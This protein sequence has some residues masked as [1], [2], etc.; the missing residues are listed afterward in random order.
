MQEEHSFKS[1]STSFIFEKAELLRDYA[2]AVE[3]REVSLLGRKDVFM[4]RA[5]FGIFGD[6]KELAQIALS[7]VFRKGD[8][9]SGYYRDQTLVAA[10]GGMTWEVFFA[11]L[12]AHPDV[13]FDKFSGGRSMNAHFGSPWLDEKGE[14]LDQ[15]SL[16]NHAMDVSSTAGQLP[17]A[18]GLAFA[19]KL[20]RQN[21]ELSYLDK[22]SKN[23]NEVCFATIGD[24]STS[25][26]M[27][28]ESINAA[29][30][31][32]IPVI[33]SV[34]DDGFGISVP[35]KYQTTKSS[36]STILEGFQTDENG[37][38]LEIIKVKGWDYPALIEAYQKAARYARDNH[39]PCLVHVYELT[40]PQG[41]SASG[42]HERY[43]SKERL[44]WEVD[45][46][47]NLRFRNWLLSEG[48]ASEKELLE[49]ETKASAR[50]KEA[51]Q[52]AWD[53][54]KS[55][56]ENSIGRATDLLEKAIRQ[57][58]S[59]KSAINTLKKSIQGKPHTLVK[60]AVVA[61]RRTQR[62]LAK[63][64]S[65]VKSEI[66][67]LIETLLKEAAQNYSSHLYSETAESPL[68]V[69]PEA[70][71]YDGEPKILSGHQ[72]IN[73]YF[74]GL[75]AREP[76]V[77]AI[78]EDIG[79][80]GDV[81]QGFAGLQSKYGDLR[82]DDTGIRE[83]TIIGQGIGAAMRGLRPIVEV[84]YFDYI[85]YC[86]SL[87]TDDLASLRYRTFG[88]Q[89]APLIVRTRGHRLE[90]IWHSGS[91]MAV[92]INALR[93]MHIATPRNFV[94]AAG[95]YNTL[96]KGDDPALV[97]EPLNSYRLKEKLPVN[98]DSMC[99]PLGV[100]EVLREGKDVTIVTYGSMCHIV[101]SA[102]LQLEDYGVSVEVIDVQTLLPFDIHGVI[103]ESI[104]KTNR[105]IF[106]DEDMPGGGAAYM[107]QEVIEKQ[108]AFF[109]L[110]AMPVTISA[111]EHRPP[112]G[113]DGDYFSKPN[114][115][116]IFNAAY[117]IMHE[118]QPKNFPKI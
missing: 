8:F 72:I 34:W 7:K 28:F 117:A 73:A 43:K 14:W 22:F 46:D 50:A 94:Q 59:K 19:S 110:D 33:F 37:D 18:V 42:S 62:L 56:N 98:L 92:M 41:H 108:K 58:P 38:G 113:S 35:I 54:L 66:D 55:H 26:G 84:Q 111:K 114:E 75:F 93:G 48:F 103:G 81:N 68:K 9:R 78:G 60:D 70:A 15:T 85:Y 104:K 57:V 86:L 45:F 64:E 44:K 3:S 71:S 47:G 16:F 63:L 24:A 101:M 83:A 27:F 2:L 82:V 74:D 4:G 91:P 52:N 49:I 69:K 87:L 100:P 80:I 102:A 118:V 77:F 97:I 107:M 90:G 17:R 21:K 12:Y 11:Q 5:K 30:V 53:A 25:Q 6:G 112:Y 20:Y 105:V 76:R 88:Q 32:Q 10:L 79:K 95:I 29:G 13:K 67:Q 116:D 115:D 65:P 39:T 109:H 61:L 99:I 23:G 89:K 31:L 36:I 40:Q 51:R 1:L 96:I 106:A